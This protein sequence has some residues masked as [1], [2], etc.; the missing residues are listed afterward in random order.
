MKTNRLLYLIK[1]E[2]LRLHKYKVTTISILIA[3]MWSV[4]LY[5]VDNDIFNALLPLLIMI[6]ATMMSMMYIGSVMFFEKK[7][8]TMSTMLVTPSKDSEIILSKILANTIHNFFS[9]A[10]IIIA[11]VII[12]NVEMSYIL[13][14]LA[15]VLA[16]LYH[17]SIGLF[18]AYYQK[19]FT[20]M[21]MTIMAIAFILVIPSVL[22]DLGIIQGNVWEVILLINP[23]QAASV[24][25][26]SSF[27]PLTLDWKYFF[28]LAYLLISGVLIYKYLVLARYKAYAVSIS[29]V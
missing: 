11:F 14:A 6:D 23:I 27:E 3:L 19:D 4:L 7:E 13:V 12:K 24:I 10:L 2:L 26:S 5:F 15:I 29:G 8:S 28:S 16:T 17:T 22:F 1:G 21:L 9:T 25:I 18:L 20:T